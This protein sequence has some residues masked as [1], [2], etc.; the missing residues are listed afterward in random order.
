VI[1]RQDSLQRV[2]AMPEG[3]RSDYIRKLVRQIRRQQGLKEE[4]A[5]TAGGTVPAGRDPF[6]STIAKGDWYFY[7]KNLKS[8]GSTAFQQM[9]GSRPNIDNWRRFT[10]V[11]TQLRQNTIQGD[12]RTIQPISTAPDAGPASFETLFSRLPST[13]GGLQVSNDSIRR[14]LEMLGKIYINELE[15]YVSAVETYEDIRRRF[16]LEDLSADQLFQLQFSYAKTG[17]KT[18]SDEAK[19][20]L[21]EKYPSDRLAIIAATG[22][23]PQSEKAGPQ[24]TKKYEAIYD[25][26]VEGKFSEALAAKQQADSIYQTNQWSPQLLYIE[27]VYHVRQR[28]DSVAIGLFNTLIRQNPGTPLA[29]K[30]ENLME[31]LER[32]QEIEAEL[33]S[34]E[35]E[36]PAEDSLHVEPMPVTA[37]VQKKESVVSTEQKAVAAKPV[38][39]KPVADPA[40]TTKLPVQ[41][42]ALY[43]FNPDE[44]HYAVIVLNKVDPVFGNEARNAFNRHNKEKFYNQPLDVKQVPVNEN[45]R[46]LIVESFSNAPAAIDYIQKVKPVAASQIVPWLKGDKFSFTIISERNLKTLIGTKDFE[47]YKGFLDQNLP[48]K[49]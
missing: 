19:K 22:K 18:R 43:T 5:P 29:A 49:F 41:T 42:G 3:E 12:G 31:V 33:T 39:A 38:T 4:E 10:D 13:P 2:A 15:D 20:Q 32:R 11:T 14:S 36:R 6:A 44:Q 8:A 21:I 47:V 25:L 26:F 17:N 7:N 1:K 45:I 30:A 9:W 34:L 48:V 23:D 16:P 35:I 27:A 46:F 37:T 24:L 40:L 28:E